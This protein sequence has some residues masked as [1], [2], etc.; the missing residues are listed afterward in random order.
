MAT[1]V[2]GALLGEGECYRAMKRPAQAI[3]PLERALKSSATRPK[4]PLLAQI[5]FALADALWDA[6]RNR[7]R[8][9]DLAREAREGYRA[10]DD[11]DA[12][13][14]VDKWLSVRGRK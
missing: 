13:A 14:E 3:A 9:L 5:R 7:K 1:L 11:K 2:A 6:T 12:L 4:D 8:T 10:A